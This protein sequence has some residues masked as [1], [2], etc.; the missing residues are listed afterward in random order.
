MLSLRI[1]QF[2]L[3]FFDVLFYFNEGKK[4]ILN[5]FYEMTDSRFE[6]NKKPEEC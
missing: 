5:E 4:Y 1:A 3:L 2:L 6:I